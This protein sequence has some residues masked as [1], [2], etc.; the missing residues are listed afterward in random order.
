MNSDEFDS[1]SETILFH[2]LKEFDQ[3]MVFKMESIFDLKST[4]FFFP[5]ICT[6]SA[7]HQLSHPNPDGLILRPETLEFCDS[8]DFCK[9]GFIDFGFSLAFCSSSLLKIQYTIKQHSLLSSNR[10]KQ[11]FCFGYRVQLQTREICESLFLRSNA[12][13]KLFD[14]YKI[15]SDW[16][17][18][19]NVL[20]RILSWLYSDSE[21]LIFY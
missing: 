5:S 3:I 20:G 9:R 6:Q 8:F 10:A 14:S 1:L 11:W 12:T 7:V 21:K 19:V 2:L 4:L 16:L 15:T 18:M 17:Q 13:W